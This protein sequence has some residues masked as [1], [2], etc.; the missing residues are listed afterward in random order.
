[1]PYKS[2]I[3]NQQIWFIK[4]MVS[5]LGL[6]K[7]RLLR[8]ILTLHQST[9]PSIL[10]VTNQY[11]CSSNLLHWLCAQGSTLLASRLRLTEI[12]AAPD[13]GK[14]RVVV[15]RVPVCVLLISPA[16]ERSTGSFPLY[17]AWS[18]RRTVLRFARERM[19]CRKAPCGLLT[20][21]SGTNRRS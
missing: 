13:S 21:V 9:H 8:V 1:M 15:L 17:T 12:F 2:M 20:P 5:L 11:S 4:G 19:T 10:T 7:H 6:Q 14:L 16:L 3:T 18:F